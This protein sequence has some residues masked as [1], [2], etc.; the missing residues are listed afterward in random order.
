MTGIASPTLTPRTAWDVMAQ[1]R[2]EVT[3]AY[4]AFADKLPRRIRHVVGYH[5]GWWDLQGNP[6]AATGKFLRPALTLATAAAASGGLPGRPGPDVV[7]AALA[8]QLVHDASIMHDDIM[9]HDLTRRH[10]PSAWS[11]FGPEL[12]LLAGDTLLT[13]APG[14]F[15]GARPTAGHRRASVLSQAIAELCAGQAM[16]LDVEQ[17]TAVPAADYLKMIELK[18]GALMGCACELGALAAGANAGQVKAA[19]DFGRALGMAFQLV[20]DLLDIWGDPA[21]TGKPQYSDIARHKKTLP[22]IST[23]QSPLPAARAF[24]HLLAAGQ[25]LSHEDLERGASAIE[26]AGGRARTQAEADAATRRAMNLI[27]RIAANEPAG[28][29][30]RQLAQLIVQRNH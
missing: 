13:A 18:T 2:I 30:L 15:S 5:A 12:A 21:T 20:D 22:I 17:R 23:L 26:Q 3:P 28:D 27:M 6:C 8:V 25:E 29:D 24:A 7:A 1:A 9:D 10:R 16:D 19:R 4:Q 11:A 14:L